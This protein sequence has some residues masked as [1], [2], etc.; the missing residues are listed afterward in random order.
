MKELARYFNEQGLSFEAVWGRVREMARVIVES[1]FDS[2][3]R[4][5]AEVCFELFGMD[6]M[7]DSAGR[8]YLIE[9]NS[10]PSLAICG[11]LLSVVIPKLIENTLRIAV[12]PYFPP[13]SRKNYLKNL[14]WHKDSYEENR[15]QLVFDSCTRP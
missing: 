14:W 12:D 4:D 10:N 1:S 3:G 11:N 15:F 8:A 5:E 6:V 9:V 7:V 13:S 2:Y